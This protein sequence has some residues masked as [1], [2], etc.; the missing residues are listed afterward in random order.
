V[1][2]YEYAVWKDEKLDK[3]GEVVDQAVMLVEP[4][5][6][7]ADDDAQVAMLAARAIDETHMK[8][9]SRIQVVVRPF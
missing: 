3:D 7:L 1:K 6:V 8:D 2:L 5:T 9:L 4:T